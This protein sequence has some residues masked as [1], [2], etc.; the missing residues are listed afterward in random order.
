[1]WLNSIRTR[2]VHVLDQNDN[3]NFR[4]RID[5]FAKKEPSKPNFRSINNV[6][7]HNTTNDKFMQHGLNVFYSMRFSLL[8]SHPYF[9]KTCMCTKLFVS[10][11]LPAIKIPLYDIVSESRSIQ[12]WYWSATM[13]RVMQLLLF[14]ASLRTEERCSSLRFKTDI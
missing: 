10:R 11:Q 1:M 13:K 5:M 7:W 3:L 2:K 4:Y 8:K 9:I 14:S 6:S 12:T